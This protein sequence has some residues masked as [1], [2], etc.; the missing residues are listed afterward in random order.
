MR[1]DKGFMN[2]Q[3]KFGRE[4]PDVVGFLSEEGISI[5]QGAGYQVQICPSYFHSGKRS[6][7]LRQKLQG[8]KVVELMIGDEFYDDLIFGKRR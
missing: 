2:E 6:R 8:N 1:Q 5:L 4:V 3:G 7:I